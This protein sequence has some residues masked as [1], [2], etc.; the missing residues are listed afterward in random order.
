M[1][2]AEKKIAELVWECDNPEIA[3][4]YVK[5]SEITSQIDTLHKEL[6]GYMEEWETL[7][8]ATEKQ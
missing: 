2:A 7:Q 1:E 5:L 6:D 3:S 8:M 4:D